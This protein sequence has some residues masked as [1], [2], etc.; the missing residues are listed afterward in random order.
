GSFGDVWRGRL[1]DGTEVAIKCLRF[2]TI[3]EHDVKGLKRTMRELYMWSKAKHNNIQELLG[4][5]LFQGRLGM[6]SLWMANG[7]LQSYLRRNPG[8]DRYPLCVDVAAGV[9]YLHSI[10][11]VHGDLKANNIL[12]CQDGI[13][14]ISDFDHSILANSTLVFSATTNVGG[15]TLRWMAPELLL[16]SND[17]ASP[18]A[19]RTMETD[20]YALGMLRW[21]DKEQETI[22]GEVPYAEYRNDMGIYRAIDRKQVPNRP[23]QLLV[24]DERARQ[25]WALLITCWDHDPAIR[26]RVS[27]VL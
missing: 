6:V 22:S 27:T 2:H 23:A 19:R 21:P 5:I 10:G 13:A 7:N 18:P 12:V 9:S 25:M 14:K 11:M 1:H 20:I 4:V 16:S 26:P 3:E 15:G 8:V 17:E 24:P